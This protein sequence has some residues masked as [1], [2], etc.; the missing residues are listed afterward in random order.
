MNERFAITILAAGVG[1][2]MKSKRAKVL[3]AAGGRTLIEH[4][5][6][7]ARE[8]SRE[9]PEA[10]IY[11]IVG[12]QAE[13]VMAVLDRMSSGA[14]FIHQKN[15]KGGTGDAMRSG[16]K[17]LE[18]AAPRIVVFC[19]D[20]PLIQAETLRQ[21]MDFH[22]RS[23]A[24]ATVMTADMADPSRYG[25]IV[26]GADGGIEAIVEEKSASPEQLRIRE[27]NT[28]VYCFETQ[29]LFAELERVEPD[30]TTGEVYLTDVIGLLRRQGKKV[31]AHKIEDATEA[32]GINTRVEL[33]QVDALLRGRKARQ[34]MLSGVTIIRP[35]TV[36]IDPDVEA[37]IDTVI[38]P[39]VSL[40]GRTKVGENC[41]IGS[42]S[43]IR[44]SELASNVTVKESCI[45]EESKIAEG[46]SVGPFA[47]LRPES[48][49]G[50]EAR[51][52]NFVEIKKSRVGRGSRAGH[53]TYLGDATVGEN[54]NLGAGTITCNYDG[55]KKHPTVIEDNVFIGSGTELVAPVRVGRNAYVAAGSTITEEVPPDSLGI[56]RGKQ[57][58]KLGWV[59]ERKAKAGKKGS[60]DSIPAPS[61]PRP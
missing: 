30:K 15:P 11:V 12:H 52:G 34:L 35:E 28:G 7:T 10:A 45:I 14:R 18:A 29:P 57:V 5:V 56:A 24:A 43:V 23:Q 1:N 55:E 4:T 8:L 9:T 42:F 13:A 60:H 54:V 47:R 22:L 40:L 37:G 51:I 41:R 33:A 2:R 50:P 58:N 32:I 21:L 31:M 48:E 20:T 6:A 38:E 19:G 46:A 53:L 25:R 61:E 49:I 17:E 26:R 27:I 59:K 44:D 36:Q 39:G 16:R 3:H